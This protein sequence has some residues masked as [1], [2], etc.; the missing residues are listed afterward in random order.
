M[1]KGI[2]KTGCA[3]CKI[4]VLTIYGETR[5]VNK[6]DLMRFN[7]LKEEENE[8]IDSNKWLTEKAKARIRPRIYS[9]K[10]YADKD[11]ETD[12]IRF[13]YCP[14]CGEKIDWEEMDGIG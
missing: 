13:D 8:R 6:Y 10:E 12:L 1:G 3:V 4:G 7:Q 11:I 14:Y 2:T 9:L 5:I